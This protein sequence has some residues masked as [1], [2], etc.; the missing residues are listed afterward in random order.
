[1]STKIHHVIL[2]SRIEIT[3]D[4]HHQN[5]ILQHTFHKV[6]QRHIMPILSKLFSQY[7]PDDAVIHL[8]K[9]VIDIGDLNLSTLGKQLP[10]QVER[11]L[12]LKLKE[13]INKVIHNPTIDQIIPLPDA[14]MQAI[15]HYLSE[16]NFAWWMVERSEKQ[17][18]KIY[19]ELLHH[20]PLRI[21]QL[22]CNLTKK[23]KAVQRCMGL[24]SQTTLANTLAYLLKQPIPYFTPILAEIGLLL[25]QTGIL[26]NRPYTLEQQL[27]GIALLATINQQKHKVDRIGFLQMLLQQAAIQTSTS[28]EKILEKLHAYYEEN[29]KKYLYNPT[30]KA[31][32]FQLRDMVAM[33]PKYWY[34]DHNNQQKVLKELDKIGNYTMAPY[35][36]SAAIGTI[37]AVIGQPGIRSLVKSWLKEKKNREK[38]IK[39]LPDALFVAFLQSI[40]PYV[41]LCTDFEK[42][43][44]DTTSTIVPIGTIKANALAYCAF[45][46]FNEVKN[47]EKVLKVLEK[48]SSPTTIPYQLSAAIGTIKAAIDQPGVRSLVKR[49]LKEKQN[50]EIFIKRLPDGLFI[51]FLQSIDPYI[52]TL[53]ADF[54]ALVT[55]TTVT[56]APICAIKANSLDYCAFEHSKR[57]YLKAIQSLFKEYIS[58]GLINKQGLSILCATHTYHPEVEAIMQPLVSI[59]Q[60]SVLSN[61]PKI[62]TYSDGSID[63]PQLVST[64]PA[65]LNSAPISISEGGSSSLLKALE[66]IIHPTIPAD[67]RSEAIRKIKV[68]IGQP[69]I[70]SLVKNWLK[71]KATRK[72]LITRLSDALF[73]RFLQSIDPYIVTLYADF[74]ALVTATTVT[75]API[76]AIKANSLDYCAFEHSKRAYLKAIQSLFKEYISNGLINKQGLSILCA[77]HT[78]H[79]EVEAIMQP[80]VS[81]SQTSLL[82]DGP[83]I[84][85]HDNNS[86]HTDPKLTGIGATYLDRDSVSSLE[87]SLSDVV[88]FLLY[89]ELPKDQLVP[90]YLIAKRL[91]HATYQQIRDQLTP[92]CQEATILRK[93]IQHATEPILNKLLQVFVPFSDQILDRLEEV[94]AQSKVVQCTEQ[95]TNIR[96][97]KEIFIKAAIMHIPPTTEKQYIERILYHLGRQTSFS[98]IILCDQLIDGTKQT[99]D[100]HLAE[101][102]SLLKKKLAPL[103]LNKIDEVDLMFLFTHETFSLD[104]TLF[105]IYYS[106]LLPA[107]KHSVR[108]FDGANLSQS[109]IDQ[110]VAQHLSTIDKPLQRTIGTALYKQITD[111]LQGKQQ[112]VAKRW[113]LFLHTGQLEQYTDVTALWNDVIEHLPT[114]PL[115]QDKIHVRRRLIANFTTGQLM[116]LVRNHNDIGKTLANF[117]QGSYQLWCAT[118][119]SLDQQNISRN[120]FWESVL[121]TLPRTLMTKDDWLAEIITEWSNI[122][123]ITPTTLLETFQLFI[124][125][126]KGIPEVEQLTTS[127]HRLEEKYREGIQQQAAQRGYKTPILTKLYLLLNGSLSF[128]SQQ[129][130]LAMATL[131]NEL[132]QSMADQPLALSKLLKEQDNH[133]LA[134]RRMVY[135]FS[136]EITTKMIT[137]LAKEKSLFITHYLDL[138]SNALPHTIIPLHHLSRWKK[139]LC[140]SIMHYLITNNQ[141]EEAEFVHRTLLTICYPKEIVYQ[142]ITS[143]VANE[144][145]NQE[146]NK[147]IS[148]LKPLIN[149]INQN[150][151]DASMVVNNPLEQLPAT[152]EKKTAK[153]DNIATEEVRVYT[154]NTGLVF[155]WPFFYDFFKVHNLMVGNQFVCEQA[156]HNG[157]YLLQYLVTGKLK[158]P[159]WQLTLPKLLCGL[160]YDA[161]LLPYSPIDANDDAYG[162]LQSE[163][164]AQLEKQSLQDATKKIASNSLIAADTLEPIAI[165]TELLIEKVIKRWKSLKKLKETILYQDVTLQHILND[166]FLNRMGILTRQQIHDGSESTFWH[167]TVMHQEYDTVELLPPWSTTRLKLPWMQEAIVLFW[168]VE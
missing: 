50:R 69:S 6:V 147:I 12:M 97:I 148:Y 127:L 128:F 4:Q 63:N 25:H 115:A 34:Q 40:D 117:I 100:Y 44:T 37:K 151:I 95:L 5:N 85:V 121:K 1:M 163:M 46:H 135:Y 136:Q 70:R 75:S 74:V 73:I 27:H 89:N 28:Y 83:K 103:N 45:E 11:I 65:Y 88:D 77:T 101:T 62:T 120:L 42:I 78:Y 142:V 80:L 133:E 20:T 8:D 92:V 159:E 104:Q 7:V 43:A 160:A 14:K 126:T 99:N 139:E 109:V 143:T 56:S 94:I 66:T 26:I 24:F 59:T 71:E 41:N 2:R 165:H 130:P 76:C 153:K 158:S 49:W 152:L 17:I 137:C 98:P 58:N 107:I 129:Y 61:G 57:A 10:Y 156:A 30:V 33:P 141:V 125:D 38:L 47:Q 81:I 19:L 105:P 113:N 123:Q 16:G 164:V 87:S 149:Q 108:Q 86:L 145:T 39:R 91:G 150:R 22:W 146:K 119:G 138:L 13:E 79:P 166:Y 157:V 90:A 168:M 167:L 116:L 132:M 124:Q 64:Q 15:A 9:L 82:S 29:E 106:K 67:E 72:K 60:A 144:D 131:G 48:I 31:C 36:L 3:L 155:L 68:A 118:E 162:Q 84:R 102:F 53:Y 134:A 161:V 35:Q 140:I 111:S 51:R 21:A 93:L 54:V 96:L 18:E 154:K 55:A 23:E 110:L 52:V 122:L 32:I 112:R 114:F